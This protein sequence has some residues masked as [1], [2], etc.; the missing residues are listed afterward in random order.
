[1][2]IFSSS[3]SSSFPFFF[4]S[5]CQ[6]QAA[7]IPSSDFTSFWELIKTHRKKSKQI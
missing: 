3:S 7:V 2:S 1:M 6:Y 4:P 5:S